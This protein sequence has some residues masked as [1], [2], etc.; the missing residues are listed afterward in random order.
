MSYSDPAYFGVYGSL[1]VSKEQSQLYNSRNNPGTKA[2]T[3]SRPTY[4]YNSRNWR[5]YTERAYRNFLLTFRR[6]TLLLN[7]SIGGK[8]PRLATTNED[9]GR[10]IPQHHLTRSNLAAEHDLGGPPVTGYTQEAVL[11]PTQRTTTFLHHCSLALTTTL[12]VVELATHGLTTPGDTT[13]LATTVNKNSLEDLMFPVV[14][15]FDIGI[16]GQLHVFG[17]IIISA[18]DSHIW[19]WPDG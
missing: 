9:D 14:L 12:T 16:G 8:D 7:S 5:A 19:S 1:V 6:G 11:Q 3:S 2:S 13:M 4:S 18:L 17:P 10:S 15:S